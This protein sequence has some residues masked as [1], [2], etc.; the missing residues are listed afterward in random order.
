MKMEYRNL[1]ISGVKVSRLCLGTLMFGGPTTEAESM[2]MVHRACDLGINFFDTADRYNDGEAER[3]LGRAISDRRDRIVLATKGGLAV[4]PGPNDV[5]ASRAHLMR[6]VEESL[7]RLGTEY[8]DLYYLHVADATTPIEETLGTFDTL[9]RQGKIRYAGVSNFRAWELCG[10][11]CAIERYGFERISCLQPLYNLVNRDAEVELLPLCHLYGIG[12]V[13]YSPLARGVLSG[14]YRPGMSPP[15][16]SRAARGNVRMEQTELREESFI[17]AEKLRPLA[18]AHDAPLTQFC[19]AWMLANPLVTAII[20]GPRTMEQLEDN[21]G[22]LAI[23]ITPED[24]SAVD[25]LVPPG[26]HTGKGFNDP[27]FPVMGRPV[28]KK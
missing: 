21:V 6:A 19:L 7:R 18:E 11:L 22:C 3:V 25:A 5:G 13:P 1:G 9:I 26:E 20:L 15:E 8:I 16:G 24:E 17:V 14:K 4:G 12:V 23:E 28:K 2:Q 10:A 27:L